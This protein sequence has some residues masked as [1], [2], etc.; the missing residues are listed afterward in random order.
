MEKV[1]RDGEESL[2]EFECSGLKGLQKALSVASLFIGS[3]WEEGS[4]HRGIIQGH[5]S[6]SWKEV[7]G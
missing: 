4:I 6:M 3:F 2:I 5:P 1:Q 7:H